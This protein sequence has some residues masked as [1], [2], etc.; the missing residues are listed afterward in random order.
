[1]DRDEAFV[2]WSAESEEDSA[3]A[4]ALVKELYGSGLAA[5]RQRFAV[6]G[7]VPDP[8]VG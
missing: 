1:M 8:R 2:E 4:Q 7:P 6:D 3:D 5:L